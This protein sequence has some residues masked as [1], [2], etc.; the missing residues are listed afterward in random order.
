MSSYSTEGIVLHSN[1]NGEADI[2]VQAFT[3]KHGIVDILFKG[4]KKSSRRSP[5]AAEVGVLSQYVFSRFIPDKIPIAKEVHVLDVHTPL[6]EK[7]HK[8]LYLS[9]MSEIVLK[10]TP[11]QQADDYLFRMLKAALTQLETTTEDEHLSVFFTIH[12]L[13]CHGVLPRFDACV[14][15]GRETS[16][17]YHF[18]IKERGVVCPVC[19]RIPRGDYL[20]VTGSERLFIKDSLTRKFNLC[21][22][23]LIDAESALTLLFNLVMYMETYF[24]IKVQSKTFIFSDMLLDKEASL[25]QI[26]PVSDHFP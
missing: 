14:S 13:R 2:I 22:R 4:L 10:T 9:Y 15:C 21:N 20:P 25:V 24:H 8:I 19:A 16:E 7:I 26:T 6:R 11:R 1:T 23:S 12:L 5:V 3:E 18:S 17:T